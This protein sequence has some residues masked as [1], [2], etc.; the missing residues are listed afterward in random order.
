MTNQGKSGMTG[1]KIS[2]MTGKEISYIH[3]LVYLL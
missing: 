2:G 3:D 1:E